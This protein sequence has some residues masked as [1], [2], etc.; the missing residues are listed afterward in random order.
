MEQNPPRQSPV[1]LS[2]QK[3]P[4]MKRII[5]IA[6]AIVSFVLMSMSAKT[7]RLGNIMQRAQNAQETIESIPPTFHYEIAEDSTSVTFTFKIPTVDVNEDTQLYTDAYWWTVPGFLSEIQAGRAALPQR[8]VMVALP[9]A[10]TNITLTENNAQ[11]Q[12]IAGYKPTPAR[13]SLPD[14]DNKGYSFDNVPPVSIFTSA[15]SSPVATISHIS[16][17]R[18]NQYAYVYVSP[19]RYSGNGDEVDACY[20]FSYTLTFDNADNYDN[21]NSVSSSNSTLIPVGPTFPPFE[22]VDSAGHWVITDPQMRDLVSA[23]YLIVTTKKYEQYFPEFIKWK[24]SLGHNVRLLSQPNRWT[25]P[26]LKDSISAIYARNK[27]L[28]YV[29]LAGNISDIASFPASEQSLTDL[30]YGCMDGEDDFDKDLYTGRLFVNNPEEMPVILNKLMQYP[31]M[32]KDDVSFHSNATHVANY[33]TEYRIDCESRLF[34]KTSEEIRNHAMKNGMTVNR[35]YRADD[36]SVPTYW[37]SYTSHRSLMPEELRS[38]D[39][40]WA[41]NTQDIVD[42]F[43]AGK[44]YFLYRGHGALTGWSKPLFT[45]D[46]IPQLRNQDRL[47]IIF[48]I[49]CNTGNFRNAWGFARNMLISENGCASMI[50]SEDISYSGWNDAYALGMFSQ[51]WLEPEYNT[52][53][54]I[55][56]DS[57]LKLVTIPLSV[58]QN[59][60]DIDDLSLSAIMSVGEKYQS[61]YCGASTPSIKRHRE[62][63]H[64]FGDP[65]LW[66]NLETPTRIEDPHI[67]VVADEN[68]KTKYHV[69]VYA[70]DKSV[71]GF[72]N[73]TTDTAYR[74]FRKDFTTTINRKY[75]IH[76]S[77]QQW[78]RLP[79]IFHVYGGTVTATSAFTN[80]AAAMPQPSIDKV[81]QSGTNAVN[82][83]YSFGDDTVAQSVAGSVMS[84]KNMSNQTLDT[85]YLEE[86]QGNVTL[87]SERLSSGIYVVTLQSPQGDIVTKKVLIK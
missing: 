6:L 71:I 13:P 42:S 27:N 12:T 49:T 41:G 57:T 18:D 46:N 58:R 59:I 11:W 37:D 20:D 4:A 80:D 24:K 39:F 84:L 34:I 73:E 79:L 28:K 63:F 77:L 35:I 67:S 62:L 86:F 75:K 53:T 64:I 22:P 15:D 25:T 55:L 45:K 50:A 30:Y 43:N 44:L 66:M 47:P 54:V 31:F 7:L 56:N 60:P 78:N 81:V 61:L 87:C 26:E 76:I 82:V 21:T 8:L 23:D 52:N 16:K 14:N 36:G 72:Y 10:A 5:V 70:K 19:F 74:F 51:I 9:R 29:L 32:G 83:E 40:N 1:V 48:S 2:T 38:P 33:Q 68:D 85:Q 65:G 17:E 69:K 3:I